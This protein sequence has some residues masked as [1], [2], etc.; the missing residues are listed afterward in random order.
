MRCFTWLV[1][2]L[3]T[4]GCEGV[5]SQVGGAQPVST[6]APTPASPAPCPEL[7]AVPEPLR[8]L[9][10]AQYV[11]SVSDVLGVVADANVLPADEKVGTFTSNLSSPVSRITLEAY[12]AAAELGAKAFAADF[13]V[14]F[15]CDKA[16]MGEVACAELFMER[17]G[18]RLYRRPLTPDELTGYRAL[19]DSRLDYENG[20]ELL[21]RALLQSPHFL[22]RVE[23]V[24]DEGGALSQ[25]EIATRLA[26]FLWN[27]A[28]DDAL[29][30]AAR[31]GGLSDSASLA[32]QVDRLLADDRASVSVRTFHLQLLGLD[33]ERAPVHLSTP[34]WDQ[35]VAQT[36]RFADYVVRRGDG[37]LAT[38]L[39]GAFEVKENLQS[40]PLDPARRAGLL[41][42][43]AFLAGHAHA[44][45][46]S[47]VRRGTVIARNLLCIALPD[48]PPGVS[49]TVPAS[50]GTT[51]RARIATL[52]APAGCSGCHSLINPLGFGFEHFDSMGQWRDREGDHPIDPSGAVPSVESLRGGFTGARQLA[53]QLANSREVRSCVATQWLAFARGRPPAA[54]EACEVAEQ[55]AA[56]EVNGGDVRGLLRSIATSKLFLR[57]PQRSNP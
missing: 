32:V 22:Y 23:R 14:K 3:A 2:L 51:T 29:L 15:T 53:E 37:R 56:F 41:T 18:S 5:I 17:I 1:L 16:A 36:T 48:P 50:S 57:P 40:V 44:D 21:V 10:R 24:P 7:T 6:F 25:Y 19:F 39:A 9:T 26:A 34:Q 54:A 52:T 4:A 13:Q 43:P 28:P 45:S 46:S 38:L 8:R 20:L 47:P 33:P 11:N 55:V 27:G 12:A 30:E 42:L 35:A 31:V 49:T